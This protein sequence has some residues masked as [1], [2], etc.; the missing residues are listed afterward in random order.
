MHFINTKLKGAIHIDNSKYNVTKFEYM[1][2]THV[3]SFPLEYSEEN[4]IKVFHDMVNIGIDYPPY[5]QLRDFIRIFLKPLIESNIIRE[6]GRK[7]IL[8]KHF[9]EISL[10][11][12]NVK[13]EEAEIVTEKA[14]L[15]NMGFKAIRGC[16]TG[17]FTLSSQIYLTLEETGLSATLLKDKSTVLNYMIEIIRKYVEYLY[18]RLNFKFIVIDEPMLSFM[19]GVKKV[20]FDYK[21]EEIIKALNKILH[22]IEIAGIHV[23]G[24][25]PPLL[26]EVLLNTE[27]IKVL[28]HEFKDTPRNLNVYLKEELEEY[29]KYISLGCVSSKNPIIESEEEIMHLVNEGLNKFGSRLLM[30]KPDCGFRT[31]LDVSRNPNKAYEI[32]IEK[33]KRVI[34]VSSK[35]RYTYSKI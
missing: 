16:V 20:L 29:D 21:I 18:R 5:P 24:I 1:Y 22:G 6:E 13:I 33:L 25:I 7:F 10:S 3:G 11:S 17:P 35:L 27:T 15:K 34:N 23:C 32:A 8:I 12:I 2:T 26:K 4:V 19:V 28:D 14:R 31:L 9:G 30:I